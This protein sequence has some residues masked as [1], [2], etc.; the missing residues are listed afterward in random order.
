M[1]IP[2]DLGDLAPELYLVPLANT[3]LPGQSLLLQDETQ[4]EKHMTLSQLT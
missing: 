1:T 2:N 3:T 4:P